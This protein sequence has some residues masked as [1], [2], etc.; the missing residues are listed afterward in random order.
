[1]KTTEILGSLV[2]AAAIAAAPLAAAEL[3]SSSFELRP[4]VVV[5]R[6]GDRIYSMKPGG[7]LQAIDSR[8]G[9]VIFET[10]LADK[11]V[12]LWQGRL[13]AQRE[14][15][16]TPGVLEIVLIDTRRP[17]LPTEI[18]VT[19]PEGEL[20]LVDESLGRKFSTTGAVRQGD[21][22][23]GWTSVSQPMGAIPSSE[24]RTAPEKRGAARL[25]LT[26]SRA[27]PID[28]A[29]L[30][31]DLSPLP[32]A[33]QAFAAESN[34]KPA[35][36]GALIVS[37]RTETIDGNARRIVLK[38]WAEDGR[39]LPDVE[40]FRGEPIVEWPSADGRHLIVSQRVAPGEE[41]EYLWNVYSLE[42]G[43]RVGLV[44]NH[45]AKA[46]FYVDGNR[47]VHDVWPYV[48]RVDGKLKTVD[49]AVQGV[50]LPSGTAVWKQ[51]VRDTAYR[52]PF[53]P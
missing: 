24:E 38:R 19:L 23:V 4:G 9:S 32:A 17:G 18:D 30:A 11:P 45:F 47:L 35:R 40:L 43:A 44:R 41:N 28:P 2:L 36:V 16:T 27:I 14:N 10:A 12:A 5:D 46:D 37:T 53:P 26:A 52:G 49:R 51:A 13:A 21:L 8:N 3:Q 34:E 39:A 48:Y 42:T 1:M 15:K 22:L 6:D 33:V 7:G 20:A 50:D 29:A 25:D 31:E